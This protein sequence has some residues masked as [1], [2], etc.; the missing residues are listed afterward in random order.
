MHH[1]ANAANLSPTAAI[2][3]VAVVVGVVGGE[4]AP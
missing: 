2:L 1:F 4:G 3:G